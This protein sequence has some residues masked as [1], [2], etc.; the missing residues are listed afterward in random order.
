LRKLES[1]WRSS[2]AALGKYPRKT[3]K[4]EMQSV[5]PSHN[6]RQRSAPSPR[7]AIPQFSADVIAKS[8]EVERNRNADASWNFGLSYLKV[9]GVPQDERRTAKLLKKAANLGNPQAQAAL[10]NLYFRGIGVQR[11][12]VR[13]YTWASIAAAQLGGEDERLAAL[14]QRMTRAELEDANRRVQTWFVQKGAILRP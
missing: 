4:A 2:P 6:E 14:A 3:D 12:Y 8:D 11:D 13:A 1:D 10:S 9:D 7:D 5:F